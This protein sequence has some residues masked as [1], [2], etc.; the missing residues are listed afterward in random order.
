MANIYLDKFR[1]GLKAVQGRQILALL[2][3]EKERGNIKTLEEFKARLNELTSNLTSKTISPTIQLYLAD[4]GD[5]ID[6]DTYNFMLERIEDDLVTAFQE[7]NDIDEVLDSHETIINDVIIKNLE[8][9]VNDLE[10]RIQTLEFIAKTTAGFDNAVF[11]TFRI[12][13]NNR[14]SFDEGI[15]FYDPKTSLQAEPSSEAT[16]DFIGE[17]LILGS[18]SVSDTRILSVRQVFDHEATY[19]ELPIE[20]YNSNINN[21]ID[22]KIGTF[23]LQ[24]VLLSRPKKES[25]V[26]TKLELNL[27]AVQT[28]NYVQIEPVFLNYIELSSISYLDENNQ[29][30]SLLINPI[31]IN[32][33]NKLF[34]QNISTKRLY[35]TFKNRNFIKTQFEVKPNSPTVAIVRSIT[36]S[37]SL[38]SS[39]ETEIKEVVASPRLKE[40]L[41]LNN[42]SANTQKH[43]YEYFIGF[44]NLKVGLSRFKETSIFVSKSEKVFPCGQAAIKVLDKRPFSENADTVETEYTTDTQPL[45]LDTYF[46]GSIEYYLIKRDYNSANSLINSYV[47][48]M[49][50]LN[51]SRIRHERLIL[52]ER[53]NQALA[54][55]NVG[56]LQFF[57]DDPITQIY[58]YRNGEL[59]TA[60]DL[61]AINPAET[62]GWLVNS[63]FTIDIPN[64]SQPM[65]LAIQIQKPNVND[66]YTVSY[67]PK[68]STSNI[69][70]QNLLTSSAEIVDYS[71][72]VDAWIGNNNIMYFKDK[73]KSIPISYSL[74][75]LAIVLRRNSANVSLTPVVEEYLLAT[76]RIDTSK[77]GEKK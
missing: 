53:T 47:V 21:I 72:F 69:V 5:R 25:G 65:K 38:V 7:A 39:I 31:E 60:T 29:I 27:G 4:I 62:D 34:F 59:L 67:V 9:A 12:T 35:L 51:T 49:L 77:F 73:K 61:V 41:G 18:D 14:S 3:R 6:S 26:L 15:V 63:D 32:T 33:T 44:D 13:Q 36:D 56:Y 64:N 24:S 20:Y 54:T 57:T 46:R 76:S 74:L 2:N 42:I 48:P 19:T 55:N 71:G 28:I 10:S 1:S 58:V 43:Y 11:N 66:I 68:L 75:N 8:I 50:P 17:K 23:W 16:I 52:T 30:Q 37:A 22:S 45:S 70:P 40:A